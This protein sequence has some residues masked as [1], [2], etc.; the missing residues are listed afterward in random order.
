M[1]VGTEKN[2][3]LPKP[4]HDK[5]T[6]QANA[7]KIKMAATELSIKQEYK[8]IKCHLTPLLK[9]VNNMQTAVMMC[10]SIVF[11]GRTK[12]NVSNG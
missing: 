11:H 1:Q 3:C 12:K 8:L 6:N 4:D 9:A 10:I 7:D 2:D 5:N